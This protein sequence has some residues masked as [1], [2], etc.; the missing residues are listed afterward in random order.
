MTD[1]SPL[2]A[3]L[4]VNIQVLQE[5]TPDGEWQHNPLLLA[6][7]RDR[8]CLSMKQAEQ[9]DLYLASQ[10]EEATANHRYKQLDFFQ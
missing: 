6:Y 5:W 10:V 3:R 4:H 7:L 9:L 1:H 8:Y 2:I